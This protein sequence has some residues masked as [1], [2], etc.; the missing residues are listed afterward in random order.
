MESSPLYGSRYWQALFLFTAL[1]LVLNAAVAIYN[2]ARVTQSYEALQSELQMMRT[3]QSTHTAIQA[4]EISE[5][6]YLLWDDDN[7]VQVYRNAIA[8]IVQELQK[9]HA[10]RP[11]MQ[12][13]PQFREFEQAILRRLGVTDIDDLE[14]PY[15]GMPTP[16]GN[17][18]IPNNAAQQQ[19]IRA[20]VRAIE[21][22]HEEAFA[23]RKAAIA[24]SKRNIAIALGLVIAVGA[25]GMVLM[26][27]LLRRSL[28]QQARWERELL[29]QQNVLEERVASR[30]VELQTKSLELER[31]NRELESF[32]F[33]ASHDLQEPLRKIQAFGDRL[34]NRCSDALGDNVDYLDRMQSAAQ[35]M[36]DL[37]QD[38]LEYSR[39]TAKPRNL[40][41]VPLDDVLRDV[42]DDLD[43]AIHTSHAKIITVPLPEIEADRT[44]MY[45]LLQN[46]IANAIKFVGAGVSPTIEFR[47][48]KNT[49]S[50]AA[51]LSNNVEMV[52][53]HIIDNGIGF[54]KEYSEQ[55]FKPFQRLH[56]RSSYAGS[57]IGLALCQRIVERHNG[58]LSA[59]SEPGQGSKFTIA[60]P[61]KQ[62]PFASETAQGDSILAPP[63]RDV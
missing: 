14:F 13:S 42:L 1:L 23:S 19:E 63:T 49:E 33:V 47:V 11:Y 56:S 2:L 3:V 61:I 5:R 34:K 9:L 32:A 27:H 40:A 44:Q 4:L 39:V 35:R 38:L 21:A 12:A 17:W 37:L 10:M 26:Y 50:P 6:D 7:A 57:G 30:T 28:Q 41:P 54:D 52:V 59:S 58:R 45:Q 16:T 31:S 53:I 62:T 46:L 15:A 8:E 43:S 20:A 51:S 60:L 18:N 48:E 24:S 29:A 36:S 55:I 22:A 25:L